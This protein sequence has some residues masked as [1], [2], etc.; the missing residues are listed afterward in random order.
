MKKCFLLVL[1]LFLIQY[2]LLAQTQSRT[3]GW[4]A[5][6]TSVKLSK[7]VSLQAD[8]HYRTSD[9]WQH[10]QTLIIRP[11]IAY[12]FTPNFWAVLGYNHLNSRT[13]ISGHNAYLAEN[14]VWEQLWFRHPLQ[15]FTVTHR[16]TF[17][18]R[19]VPTPVLQGNDVKSSGSQY[20][21]RF[22]YWLRFMHPFKYEKTFTKGMYGILQEEL[23]LNFG[24]IA[25][26][27]GHSFDQSRTF[28]GLGY[29]FSHRIDLE[30]GY[31]YRRV[32]AKGTAAFN[33]NL[34]QVTSLLRL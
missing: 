13:S 33:D 20:V 4:F 9:T 29:R 15:K 5:L 10:L 32:Q 12:R 7:K 14:Q 24:N 8:I 2:T 26:V 23:F 17:E 25:A 18:Q 34:L 1:S 11:G 21:N 28:G 3:G 16:I 19:F 22:R 6:L 27:N 30:L 31:Q